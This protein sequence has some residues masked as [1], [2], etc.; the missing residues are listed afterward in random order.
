[1]FFFKSNLSS[2][3]FSSRLSTNYKFSSHAFIYRGRSIRASSRS[4]KSKKIVLKLNRS[5][6]YY[7]YSSPNLRAHGVYDYGTLP[8]MRQDLS[9]YLTTYIYKYIRPFRMVFLCLITVK[10]SNCL[11]RS[12]DFEY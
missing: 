11:L 1:M 2:R 10:L 5:S 3:S 7:Y 8:I 9:S 4:I 12:R 6:G